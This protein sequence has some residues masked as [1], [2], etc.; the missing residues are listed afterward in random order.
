[1]NEI[2][3][4]DN[5]STSEKIHFVNR[6][7]EVGSIRNAL[8]LLSDESKDYIQKSVF[9]LNGIGGIGKTVLLQ[10]AIK[11]CKNHEDIKYAQYDF[12]LEKEK[13]NDLEF[14]VKSRLILFGG[15]KEIS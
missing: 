14:A 3:I 2:A 9:E 13:N 4:A 12:A 15:A 1:M 6:D 8:K 11:L 5:G 7:D 10:N